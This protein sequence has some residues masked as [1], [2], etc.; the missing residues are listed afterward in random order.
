[1]LD[2]TC[3]LVTKLWN[4]QSASENMFFWVLSTEVIFLLHEVVVIAYN[5]KFQ[6]FFF[7][8]WKSWHPTIKD[9]S[10]EVR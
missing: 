6:N 9:D 4:V 8:K 5:W 1:M 3:A 10:V 2:Q 7:E